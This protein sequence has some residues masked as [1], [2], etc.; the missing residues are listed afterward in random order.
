[1]LRK[2]SSQIPMRYVSNQNVNKL[3]VIWIK[4]LC[5]ISRTTHGYIKSVALPLLVLERS[6]PALYPKLWRDYVTDA[7]RRRALINVAVS[8]NAP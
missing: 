2:I 7:S 1:M 5:R 3:F 4:D 6:V 8:A